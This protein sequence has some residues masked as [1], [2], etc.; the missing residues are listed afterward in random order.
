MR[1]SNIQVQR[2]LLL[3]VVVGEGAAVLQMLASEVEALPA[4]GNALPVLDLG[5]HRFD[6]VGGINPKH[7]G[8]VFQV[9]AQYLHCINAVEPQVPPHNHA[10]SPVEARLRLQQQLLRCTVW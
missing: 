10:N 5:P 4:W 1:K 8:F 6:G 3:H 7:D 2:A 9:H